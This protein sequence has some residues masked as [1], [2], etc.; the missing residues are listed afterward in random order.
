VED[1]EEKTF[2]PLIRAPEITTSVS[3]LKKNVVM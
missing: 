3:S 1:L 2:F